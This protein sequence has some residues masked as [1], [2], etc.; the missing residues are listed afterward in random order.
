MWLHLLYLVYYRT[1]DCYVY[2]NKKSKEHQFLRFIE[3]VKLLNKNKNKK[4]FKI[5][6]CRRISVINNNI[7]NRASKIYK[8]YMIIK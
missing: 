2:L 1:A 6:N 4:I 7:K 5:G 3:K 8:L